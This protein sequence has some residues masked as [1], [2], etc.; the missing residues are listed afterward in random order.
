MTVKK[1]KP[2]DLVGFHKT[3]NVYE[4]VTN[5]EPRRWYRFTRGQSHSDKFFNTKDNM[6]GVV[7]L[8]LGRN[9]KPSPGS[10]MFEHLLPESDIALFPDGVFHFAMGVLILFR[11]PTKK[12]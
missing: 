10:R 2:G 4:A 12:K 3:R 6:T 9:K 7:G 5:A 8:Y 11:K 1:L